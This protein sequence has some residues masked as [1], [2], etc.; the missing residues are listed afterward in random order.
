MSCKKIAVFKVKITVKVRSCSECFTEQY[1]WSN[2]LNMVVHHHERENHMEIFFCYFQGQGHSH[3]YCIFRSTETFTT[4]ISLMMHHHKTGLDT[5]KRNYC[6][7][8]GWETEDVAWVT[9][10]Q[11]VATLGHPTSSGRGQIRFQFKNMW[12]E[13]CFCNEYTCFLN[14]LVN[15][16]SVWLL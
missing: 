3:F 14:L 6:F 12:T 10:D 13:H 1:L 4:Q 7:Y 5:M 9:M 2:K 11:I 15:D 16:S 8:S